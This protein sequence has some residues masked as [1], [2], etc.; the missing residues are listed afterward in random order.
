MKNPLKLEKILPQNAVRVLSSKAA[1]I[2]LGIIFIFLAYT[3]F[4][5][6]Q[7]K[8]QVNSEI[9]QLTQQA[10]ELEDKNKQI[11]DSLTFLNSD[12]FKEKIAREQL[13]LKKEGELV[14]DTSA[15]S[16]NQPAASEQDVGGKSN[17]SKWY[18]YFFKK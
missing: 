9:K 7:K 11:N 13:N 3:E 2:V 6:W 5:D 14:F 16:S 10:A 1:L 18:S 17:L 15:Q 12:N 8:H 4:T